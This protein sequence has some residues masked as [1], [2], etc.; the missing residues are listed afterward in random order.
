MAIHGWLTPDNIPDDQAGRLVCIP[1]D[2]LILAAVSGAILDL[3]FPYN[4][5]SYGTVTPEA[6]AAAMSVMWESFIGGSGE[7]M[8]RLS[9]PIIIQ[10]QKAQNTNGGTFNSGA[11]QQRALNTKQG[12]ENELITLSANRFTVPAGLWY[13]QWRAPCNSVNRHQTLLYNVTGAVGLAFGTSS[14]ASGSGDFSH[15]EITLDLP[16]A[17]QMELQHRC[18]TSV[19]STGFGVAGNFGTEIY[20]AVILTLIH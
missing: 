15:G 3:T 17:T 20:S 1:N 14:F 8:P 13:F 11:W 7:C 19:A 4:W 18:Q 5:E 10:D 16:S 9:R 2:P 12:D 6:M